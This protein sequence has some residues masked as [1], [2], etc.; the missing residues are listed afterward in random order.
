MISDIILNFTGN[1]IM[2]DLIYLMIPILS[3][4][5]IY[6]ILVFKLKVKK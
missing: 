3:F 6:Q 5:T 1:K 2:N 4:F